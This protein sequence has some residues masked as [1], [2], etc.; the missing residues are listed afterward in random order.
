MELTWDIALLEGLMELR[1]RK[2]KEQAWDAAC[3]RM[4]PGHA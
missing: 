3:R 2:R 4:T 1:E